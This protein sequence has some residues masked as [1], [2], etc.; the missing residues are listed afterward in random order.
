MKGLALIVSMIVLMAAGT[1]AYRQN[2]ET[3]D[4][5]GESR[6]LQSE[7]AEARQRL[8][9]LRAEWA[10][11]NRPDRLRELTAMNFDRL[12]LLPLR[13]DQFARIVDLDPVPVELL[14]DDSRDVITANAVTVA[15]TES[16]P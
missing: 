3:R 5:F 6:Q 13:P 11:L 4:V 8:G 15:Y 1:W 7:I 12:E 9:I 2:Y 10:Y 14:S 16:R